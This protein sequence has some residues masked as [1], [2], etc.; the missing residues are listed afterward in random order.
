MH[1]FER[2]CPTK[3][4]AGTIQK[5]VGRAV[6]AASGQVLVAPATGRACLHYDILV[7]EEDEESGHWRKVIGEAQSVACLLSDETGS[8]NVD[9]PGMPC[10]I[11]T[12]P[13]WAD[14]MSSSRRPSPALLALCARFQ[15][16]T[17]AWN[18]CEGETYK[19]IRATERVIAVGQQCAALG[20]VEHDTGQLSLVPLKKELLQKDD[21]K[22]L[23]W[24]WKEQASWNS[25]LRREGIF[26]STSSDT[27]GEALPLLPVPATP[28]GREMYTFQAPPG[29]KPGSTCVFPLP[30]G[31]QIQVA[32][33]AGIA[34]GMT[35]QV[36]V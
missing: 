28:V 34:P 23:E 3:A 14:R 24:K 32:V 22:R 19:R 13:D 21:F 12:A 18:L 35:F 17:K 30:D 5:V 11:M 15:V 9:L 1:K 10:N 4:T 16:Q 33:P 6:P 8:V 7:E 31:R 2:T 20:V 29:S 25:L 36:S 26:L 27:I